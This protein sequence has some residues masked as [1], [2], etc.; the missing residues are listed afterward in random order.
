MTE[1]S[2]VLLDSPKNEMKVDATDLASK[3]RGTLGKMEVALGAITEAIAWTDESGKVQWSN[4]T[5]DRLVAKNRFEILGTQLIDLLPL[6]QN[7]EP[8]SVATHP[9]TMAFKRRM[10]SIGCY[11]LRQQETILIVEISCTC[12]YLQETDTSVVVAIRDITQRQQAAVE[13]KRHQEQFQD[14]VEERTTTLLHIN[15]Q[16]QQEICDR[17]YT[18]AVLRESEAKNR[19]LAEAATVQAQQLN[20][21]LLELKQTQT[22]LIQS[23]KM[24]SLGQMVAG[25]AHEINNPVNFIYGNLIHAD[26]YAQNLLALLQ[27]YQ[28][29]YPHPHPKVTSFQEAIELDFLISDLPQ[30]LASMQVGAERIREIVLSLRTFA[31]LDEAERKA[32]DIHAGIDSTLLILESRLRSSESYPEITV[33]KEY[34]DLPKVECYAS[35]LNQVLMNL[36][37]N[38]IDA[39]E[40]QPEP[41]AITIKTALA[42]STTKPGESQA[43]GDRVV[44]RI[45]DNGPG[46]PEIDQAKIFEPFFTTKMMQKRTGLGLAISYQIIVDKHQGMLRCVSAPELGTEFWIEIPLQA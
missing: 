27:L 30:I 10:D 28:Q 31:H 13:L 20:Q 8:V 1:C 39:L 5:F 43:E 29:I 34:G 15:K 14:L 21:T 42:K 2:H 12:I 32:V 18:E 23:A 9:I 25:I 3:L 41:R 22:Q 37:S 17:Q 16:L 45:H 11:E 38:A 35:Q 46:I 33:V 36:L 26:Q 6:T 19:A 24:S 44:I 7:D 4:T 40:E